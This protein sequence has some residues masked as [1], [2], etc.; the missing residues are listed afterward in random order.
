MDKQRK[1][2]LEKRGYN[3]ITGQY[4]DS[5]DG[6]LQRDKDS[7][8]DKKIASRGSKLYFN[9]NSFDIISGLDITNK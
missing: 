3:I 6:T 9:K 1:G 4:T 7:M 5:A 2:Q 8:D